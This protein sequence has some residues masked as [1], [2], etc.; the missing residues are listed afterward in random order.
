MVIKKTVFLKLD[1]PNNAHEP[2]LLM[3]EDISQENP[4]ITR[5]TFILSLPHIQTIFPPLHQKMCYEMIFYAFNVLKF[6]LFIC[7][8]DESKNTQ[9]H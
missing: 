9:L 8:C 4:K 5:K 2:N 6:N 7:L 3:K 1:C